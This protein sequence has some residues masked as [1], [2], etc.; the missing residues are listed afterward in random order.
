MKCP[1]CSDQ[2]EEC[3]LVGN[4]FGV[5]HCGCFYESNPDKVRWHFMKEI[6]TEDYI[7]GEFKKDIFRLFNSRDDYQLNE[8]AK[9]LEEDLNCKIG[10]FEN[11]RTGTKKLIMEFEYY[12]LDKNKHRPKFCKV[13][14]KLI[15]Q[16][17]D[18]ILMK[19]IHDISEMLTCTNLEIESK[20]LPE[21]DV[22]TV[23][24][25]WKDVYALT[26]SP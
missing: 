13:I 24:M 15:S 21:D 23:T 3:D 17:D 2:I 5:T 7:I 10:T 8:R 25:E 26:I 14:H 22:I 9:M 20:E 4:E 12:D 6:E 16:K 11:L 18:S 1:N 19:M